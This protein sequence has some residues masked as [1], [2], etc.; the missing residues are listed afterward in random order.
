MSIPDE[1]EYE[2]KYKE[3]SAHKPACPMPVLMARPE[4]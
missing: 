2:G 4:F 1:T 3:Q